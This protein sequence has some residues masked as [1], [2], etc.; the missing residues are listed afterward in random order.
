MY[1]SFVLS[2]ED[3][4]LWL[5]KYKMGSYYAALE[6]E[7]LDTVE[8]LILLS[9]QEIDELC[10]RIKMKLG[11]KKR[12]PVV[13]AEAR[14]AEEKKKK[15]E[16]ER[17]EDAAEE[18]RKK[19]QRQE[20]KEQR[21]EQKAKQDEEDELEER[22]IAKELADIETERKLAKA[23]SARV[24]ESEVEEKES[25]TKNAKGFSFTMPPGKNHFAFLSHKKTNSKL[26]GNTETLALRVRSFALFVLLCSYEAY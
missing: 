21:V 12:F 25:F 5:E 22:K 24:V 11:H 13:I 20:Q 16:K 4:Q 18:K 9:E 10:T 1:I 2:D 8:S 7:G 17:E 23:R 19:K 6:E 26:A 15:V 3:F 14:E